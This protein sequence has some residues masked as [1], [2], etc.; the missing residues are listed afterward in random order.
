M[1]LP[2]EVVLQ[3]AGFL[4]RSEADPKRIMVLRLMELAAYATDEEL[5][6]V[7]WILRGKLDRRNAIGNAQPSGYAGAE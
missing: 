6:E 5:E 3:E 7:E 4:E 2:F 1:G